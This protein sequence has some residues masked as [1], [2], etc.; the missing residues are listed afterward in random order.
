MTT[1]ERISS[2][3]QQVSTVAAKVDMAI[4]ELQQQRED[5]RRLQERQ[6]AISAKHDAEMKALQ[7]RQ[8]AKLHE[9]NERFYAKIDD[10]SKQI[11]NTFIQTMIG[12]GAIMAALAALVKG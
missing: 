12:V 1:D 5:M 11:H 3:E 4:A 10:L 2:L 8:D 9:A 7:E 6:D